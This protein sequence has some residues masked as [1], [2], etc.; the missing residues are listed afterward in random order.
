MGCGSSQLLQGAHWTAP[1]PVW[2]C[3]GA[4]QLSQLPMGPITR[5][6]EGSAAPSFGGSLSL[7][8]VRQIGKEQKQEEGSLRGLEP[9]GCLHWLRVR[10]EV[11]G[12]R[13]RAPG[14]W[15]VARPSE[16][17]RGAALASSY[18]DGCVVVAVEPF[19]CSTWH[20][21]TAAPCAPAV[22]EFRWAA[23]VAKAPEGVWWGRGLLVLLWAIG[24]GP[25]APGDSSPIPPSRH[26]VGKERCACGLGATGHRLAVSVFL[27]CWLAAVGLRP[28]F[29]G[30]VCL[31]GSHAW[32]LA[33][34]LH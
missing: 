15:G 17:H 12:T 11:A 25:G 14:S 16:A 30:C 2:S 13:Q 29:S 18:P 24:W 5:G 6:P 20:I 31:C 10:R 23:D 9:Q 27:R 7:P 19:V 33:M 4:A 28:G 8:G 3:Q 34:A 32:T 26:Q 1:G 22:A 21:L